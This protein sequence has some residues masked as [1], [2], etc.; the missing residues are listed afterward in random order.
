MIECALSIPATESWQAWVRAAADLPLL[1][2]LECPGEL[3]EEDG[4]AVAAD[5][6]GL[7]WVHVHDLL[8][9]ATARHLA[10]TTLP[11]AA[12][13]RRSIDRLTGACA[14]LG[15]RRASLD[16]G[17]DRLIGTDFSDGLERR[18]HLLA[19][20]FGA[21]ASWPLD[22]CVDVRRPPAFPGSRE[23]EAAGNLIH[24]LQGKPFGLCVD[25]YPAEPGPDFALDEFLRQCVLHTRV[26]RI[27][28]CPRLGDAIDCETRERWS[29]ALR[30]HGFRG[31]V[32][33]CPRVTD[34]DELPRIL[35]SADRW[36]AQ[37]RQGIQR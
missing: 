28:Y 32:V 35:A 15:V 23:W 4:L 24:E 16:L 30:R 21:E 27:L 26:L 33:F 5:R 17:L 13:W 34:P 2:S 25:V 22:L 31:V 37:L 11:D 36:A 9:P 10:E 19:P 20:F 3:L 18:L 8:P 1:R 7:E 12:S 14:C 6:A 29:T